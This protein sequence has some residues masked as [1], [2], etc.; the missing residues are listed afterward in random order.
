[1]VNHT[2]D[3]KDDGIKDAS[4]DAKTLNRRLVITLLLSKLGISHD[5]NDLSE[6]Y[7]LFMISS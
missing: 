2:F 4:D 1:M 5:M 3:A 6:I 7:F